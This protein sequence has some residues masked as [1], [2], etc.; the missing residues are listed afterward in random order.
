MSETIKYLPFEKI[1]KIEIYQ[2]TNKL[3]IKQIVSQKNP[4]YAITGVFYNSSWKPTCQ[5]KSNGTILA[6]DGYNY[7]GYRWNTPDDF[8]MGAVPNDSKSYL[9]YMACCYLIVD[10]KK[11]E[12]PN[13]NS[14]VGGTRGRTGI[15]IKDGSLVIYASTDGSSNAKTPEKLRDYLFDKGLNSFVMCDGGGKVNYY[16]E[17]QYFVGKDKSQ[18]LFLVYLKKESS[19]TPTKD[20]KEDNG[21][22]VIKKFITNNP[23]YKT[24]QVTTKTGYVQHS[25]GT[26]GAMATSIINSFNSSSAQAEAHGVIDD[27]GIYQ[28]LPH[29]IRAWHVGGSANTTHVGVE[30]CEPQDTRFLDANWYNLSQNGKN[31]TTFAVKA[32]QQELVTRGYNTNGVDG[33][34]GAG[35]KAAVISFQKAMGLSADGIVGENTLHKLQEREGSYVKYYPKKNQAYFENVYNKSVFYCAA[36]LKEIGVSIIDSNSVLSHAEAYKK[37]IGSNHADTGHWWPEHGKT[38]DDF[39]QDVKNYIATGK[40]PYGDKIQEDEVGEKE[41]VDT[42]IT[43][44][45]TTPEQ[46]TWAQ[47]SWQKAYDKGIMDGTNPK[48]ALTREQMAVVLDR[49]GLLD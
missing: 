23:R 2:N 32:V 6:N 12:K 34:F 21:L 31:N 5:L 10:G 41:E 45:G 49:L 17:G 26:P 35:T 48:N 36:I 42:T 25:T 3:T 11:I 19:D 37:G 46:S 38:M 29:N 14:D 4:D 24:N 27:T 40:L 18:N 7:Y 28:I 39:R 44:K 43:E 13:Y 15:G 22:E 1:E 8:S 33:I 16:G 9:N 20:K 47:T 30:V